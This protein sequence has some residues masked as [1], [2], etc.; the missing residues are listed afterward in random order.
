MFVDVIRK[1]SER[2]RNR[3]NDTGRTDSILKTVIKLMLINMKK[4]IWF[5]NNN[6]RLS[7]FFFKFRWR[8]TAQ[9]IPKL[10]S[11]LCVTKNVSHPVARAYRA[12]VIKNQRHRHSFPLNKKN[13]IRKGKRKI[14]FKN[15]IKMAKRLYF[16][17]D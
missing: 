1:E 8:S 4:K 14:K 16:S 10:I 9:E 12:V 5:S 2:L 7:S 6:N 11:F 17:N 3:Q 15:K 13:P